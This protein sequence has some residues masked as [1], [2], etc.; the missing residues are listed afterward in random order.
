MNAF[1]E[2]L[3]LFRLTLDPGE[4]IVR[5]TAVYWFLFLLFRFVMRRDV[6]AIAIADVLLL[7]MI[8]DASQSAMAGDSKSIADGC[9]LVATIAGWN[10]LLD[11]SSY[12]LPLVRRFVEAKPLL[13][14]LN[15]RLLRANL[16]R[17]FITIDELESKMREAG[18]ARLDAVREAYLE[19][20]G[21]I[22]LLL[23]EEYESV[24]ID[25]EKDGR[26]AGLPAILKPGP[27]DKTDEPAQKLPRHTA[28]TP[29]VS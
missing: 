8:A 5:G 4:I 25:H 16:R 2:F 13:L 23:K 27:P 18:V 12:R 20:D 10:Y 24:A 22:S 11:W 9:L 1:S 7:V 21:E 26:G 3:D 14:V 17:E 15:G 28:R 19:S 6:G 29:L